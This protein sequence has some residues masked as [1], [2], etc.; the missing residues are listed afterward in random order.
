MV[1]PVTASVPDPASLADP[2]ARDAVQRA[3]E[4]MGLRPGQPIGEIAV[5]RVFIGSC[6][7]ARIEDLRT[8]GVGSRRQ[9]DRTRV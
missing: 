8:A 2:G 3:L 5:D 9:A 4:Y 6:T 1:L 7:N